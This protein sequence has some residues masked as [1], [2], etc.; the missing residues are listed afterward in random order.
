MKQR[1]DVTGM[2]CAACSARVTK[3]TQSVNG[4]QSATVNLLKNSMD[5]EYDGTPETLAAIGTAVEKAG[6]GAFPHVEQ[7]AGAPGAPAPAPS[8]QKRAAREIKRV[9]TRLIV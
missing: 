5:V 7:I 2:T 9:K 1:F 6:Y 4:V 3:A 8:A